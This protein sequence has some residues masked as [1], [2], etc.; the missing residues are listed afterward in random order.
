MAQAKKKY[1]FKLNPFTLL[2]TV[3][4]YSNRRLYEGLFDFIFN[5]QAV[6]K[7]FPTRSRKTMAFMARVF[8]LPLTSTVYA[9]SRLV[10][11]VFN[12][13]AY[14][15]NPAKAFGMLGVTGLL[16]GVMYKLPFDTFAFSSPMILSFVVLA[17]SIVYAL[18]LHGVKKGAQQINWVIEE[19]GLI[20]NQVSQH[21]I[22][23]TP[24]HLHE[25]SRSLAN[26]SHSDS[27]CS[28][29]YYMGLANA[30]VLTKYLAEKK[31]AICAPTEKL[32]NYKLVINSF[33]RLYA[34]D[35]RGRLTDDKLNDLKNAVKE[36]FEDIYENRLSR[37]TV[38]NHKLM[39]RSS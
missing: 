34:A 25:W 5:K 1:T 29:Y 8:L 18:M 27:S 28:A 17:T 15:D 30:G 2:S 4:D 37:L 39:I 13:K 20:D 21:R 19:D 11:V 9:V 3:I 31:P 38:V 14:Q 12:I 6:D 22:Q 26:S 24:K 10:L 7:E 35:K 23:T 33:D 36:N 32:S 16:A